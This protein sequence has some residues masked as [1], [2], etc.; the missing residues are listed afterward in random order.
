MK[1]AK[2]MLVLHGYF[3]FCN[4]V[5]L[6]ALPGGEKW[7]M[8]KLGCFMLKALSANLSVDLFCESL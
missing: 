4:K 3:K 8:A 2:D 1:V 5:N 6:E 7:Q